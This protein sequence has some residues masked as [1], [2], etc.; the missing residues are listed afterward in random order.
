MEPRFSGAAEAGP[1]DGPVSGALCSSEGL[2]TQE[3]GFGFFLSEDWKPMFF[4]SLARPGRRVWLNLACSLTT[5][6]LKSCMSRSVMCDEAFRKSEQTA[7]HELSV[8]GRSC[9]RDDIS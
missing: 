2:A 8:I 5:C 7:F 1:R 3:G 9:Q 4:P 6:S